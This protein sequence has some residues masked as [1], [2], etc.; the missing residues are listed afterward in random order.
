MERLHHIGIF[1]REG[2]FLLDWGTI[3]LRKIFSSAPA[4]LHIQ[5]S[6]AP[7]QALIPPRNGLS[8][9][10]V[11]KRNEATHLFF[12]ARLCCHWC[13]QEPVPS[14]W[15]FKPTTRSLSP[16]RRRSSILRTGSSVQRRR[17]LILLATVKGNFKNKQNISPNYGFLLGEERQWRIYS[18]E[19]EKTD[20]VNIQHINK[21]GLQTG[22]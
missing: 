16:L 1:C 10:I 13:W 11:L 18:I 15:S 5:H 4:L 7:L 2:R 22:E 21:V 9:P 17:V 6:S 14:L 20:Y 3:F 19:K 12:L 8:F